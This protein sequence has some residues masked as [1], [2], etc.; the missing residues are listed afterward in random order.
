MHWCFSYDANGENNGQL[1]QT[2][3]C[4]F[5]TSQ[6]EILYFYGTVAWLAESQYSFWCLKWG[7][8]IKT[9]PMTLR[10]QG[11]DSLLTS[12]S[13]SASLRPTWFCWFWFCSLKRD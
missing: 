10:T 7:G 4:H 11:I 13:Q 1:L 8:P 6:T 5:T 2:F 3:V 9:L 12:S